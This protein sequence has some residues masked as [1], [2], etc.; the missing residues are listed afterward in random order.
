M[1]RCASTGLGCAMVRSHRAMRAFGRRCLGRGAIPDFVIWGS[2]VHGVP[3]LVKLFGIESPG[4][5][6]AL[7]IAQH[8]KHLL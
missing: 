1:P 7:T 4:L 2:A 3:G 8:V 5:T 6:S